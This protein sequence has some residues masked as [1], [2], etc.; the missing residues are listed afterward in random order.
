MTSSNDENQAFEEQ[1]HK[2]ISV[3]EENEA[4][5]FELAN[6]NAIGAGF[7]ETKSKTTEDLCIK[8]FVQKKLR[9][10]EL[11]DADMVPKTLGGI[12]TDV[13]PIGEIKAQ[14][15]TARL[16][17]AQPGYSIGHFRITAGTFGC[18]VRDTCYPCRYYILS[19]NH[20]LANS[21]AAK[22]GDAILQP[23]RIDGGNNPA[24]RIARL[25]RFVPIRFGSLQ[26]Y[27]LVDAAI[28]QPLDQRNVFASIKNLGIPKGTEEATI[29]MP[30]IKTGRTTQT[31]TGSVSAVNVTVAVNFGSAGVAYF[32]NQFM[33]PDMSNPGDSGSV[34]LS[35]KGKKVVGLLFAGSSQVTIFNNIH[36]VMMALNVTPVTA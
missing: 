3:Q 36:N 28:A 20:V 8:V 24:D 15:Y 29:G 12:K 25:S 23:G 1:L 34:L 16:R 17:P 30:V 22:A 19:N 35:R 27:N 10:A 7:K 18:M 9:K 31:T 6:V 5:L 11:D 32:K 4:T 33:T 14:A 21:N 26:K 2:V 13:V